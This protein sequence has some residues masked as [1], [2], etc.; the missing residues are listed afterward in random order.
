MANGDFKNLKEQLLIK[1]YIIVTHLILL[2]MQNV[3][4]I[5]MD[6]LQSFINILI[7]RTSGSGIK[8]TSNKELA[9]ELHKP[10]IRKCNKRKV[11]LPFI[12][13]IWGADLADVQLIS[14]FSKGFRFLI[15]VNLYL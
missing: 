15:C 6:L 8:N 1:S 3:M 9:G 14:K 7:K 5:N 11:H 10:I 4:D 13:K 12:E 2:K